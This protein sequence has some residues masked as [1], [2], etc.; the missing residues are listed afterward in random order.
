MPVITFL[1]DF[2]TRDIFVGVCHGVIAAGAPDAHV[3]HLGHAVPP[4]DVVT[5][6]MRLADGVVHVQADVHLAVVD[7]GVGTSRLA[8]ILETAAGPALVGPDNGLLLPAAQRLGGIR[9]AWEITAF[10]R[11]GASATFHGRDVFAP[12]AAALAAGQLPSTLGRPADASG[13][14]TLSLP[15][16]AV[17][18]GAIEATIRDVDRYGNAQLTVGGDELT[19]AAGGPDLGTVLE[20]VTDG[21]RTPA[22]RVRT[23]ADLTGQE[24]GVLLDSF[25]WLAVV[26]RGGSAASRLDVEH[27]DA[28]RIHWTA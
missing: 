26:V 20:V 16:P 23:F 25:G 5:G 27:G 2:G 7:P 28:I 19:A 14:V 13:L 9:A 4:Q 11:A 21:V 22:R 15:E 8:V 3:V 24:V 1:S 18:P 6:A 10:P 12:A 17:R